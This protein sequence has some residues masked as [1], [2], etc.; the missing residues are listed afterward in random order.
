[1]RNNIYKIW[2]AV[3]AASLLVAGLCGAA[4][5]GWETKYLQIYQC[6]C[7]EP[8]SVKNFLQLKR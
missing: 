7:Y 1:M 4:P 5:A 2:L 3:G 6:N 8:G